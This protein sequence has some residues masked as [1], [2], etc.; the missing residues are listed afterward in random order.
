VGPAVRVTFVTGVSCAGKTTV[1]HL[2]GGH[3]RYTDLLQVRDID[4]D[5]PVRPQTAWLDWLRWRAAEHLHLATERS[6]L[7]AGGHTVITGISWPFRVVESPAW[8]PAMEAGVEV[9]FVMLDPP[10]KILKGRLAERTAGKPKA[11]AK[12][13]RDYNRA[14]RDV[15]RLQ[16]QAVRNGHVLGGDRRVESLAEDIVAG[17]PASGTAGGAK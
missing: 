12:E 10:W 17:W 11:E 1:A 15:L 13:L 3:E 2:L 8:A 5:A 14:L 4:E 7:G 6:A 9:H 16:V